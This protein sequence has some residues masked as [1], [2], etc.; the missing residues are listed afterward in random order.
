MT[1]TEM[2]SD[3]QLI[4]LALVALG[5][6]ALLAGIVIA[7]EPTSRRPLE[8]PDTSSPRATIDTLIRLT[9]EGYGYWTSPQGRSHSNLVERMTVASQLV[10]CFDLSDIPPWL[11]DNVAR[12]TAVYLKE[13][14]DRIELPP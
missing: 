6:M 8:P 10:Y 5:V 11:Q 9:T 1:P 13:V 3:R 12:E 7:Q 14:F 2:Q 4:K